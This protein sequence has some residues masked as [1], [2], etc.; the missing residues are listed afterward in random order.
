MPRH[1]PG[2]AVI[3]YELRDPKPVAKCVKNRCGSGGVEPK[4]HPVQRNL[5][6]MRIG[7]QGH[8]ARKKIQMVVKKLIS[9][10]ER[11]YLRELLKTAELAGKLEVEWTID[12]SGRVRSVR[13]LHSSVKSTLVS[14]CVLDSIRGWRFP[15]PRGGEV[16]VNYPFFFNQPSTG[17]R[18]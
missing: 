13:Q 3:D 18:P 9:Q 2:D 11:C 16:I 15:R 17:F 14:T 12:T 8:L 4:K 10:V 6:A 1:Q 5:E 7:G